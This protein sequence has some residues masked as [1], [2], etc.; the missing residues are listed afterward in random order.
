M[1]AM[2]KPDGDMSF[3]AAA[4]IG[5]AWLAIFWPIGWLLSI[6]TQTDYNTWMLRLVPAHILITLVLVLENRSYWRHI[7]NVDLHMIR[8]RV[9]K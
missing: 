3:A 7:G 4:I 8:S 6:H 5:L 2:K 9:R 1:S